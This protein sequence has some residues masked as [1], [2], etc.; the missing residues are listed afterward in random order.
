MAQ[1]GRHFTFREFDCRDGTKCPVKAHDEVRELCARF[2][3]P[4][5]DRFGPVTILSGYRTV[6][7]NRQVG[8]A[9]RSFH[10]YTLDPGR[11][12][13]ADV[14]CARG[15]VAD[16][17]AFLEARNPGGLGRYVWGCHVD[18]RLQRARW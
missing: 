16:W 17:W 12:V 8:G 7:Y 18:T 9:R 1:A 11:G 5:R 3:D 6:D 10:I 15:T 13:A 2:L 14:R 4:L